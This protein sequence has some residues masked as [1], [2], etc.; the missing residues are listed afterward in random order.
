L[1]NNRVR[2][3]GY[4]NNPQ[5][6]QPA[7]M[8][9]AQYVQGPL[10]LPQ[11]MALFRAHLRQ[12]VWITAA[13]LA[14]T[15]LIVKLYPK[16]YTAEATVLVNFESN[17]STRQAPQELYGS[18]LATQV[19]LLLDRESVMSAIDKLNLTSDPEF[20][21]GFRDNGTA[22][23]R[24]WAERQLRAKLN[25]QQSKGT[26][27]ILVSV[28]S[29]DRKKAALIANAIVE[30]YQARQ[31]NHNE[32]PSNRATEYAGQLT[33]L[34]NKVALAEQHMAE[35][36]QRTGIADV[37]RTNG[38][39]DLESQTLQQLEQEYLGAQNSRRTAEAKNGGDQSSS[40]AAL[41]SQV[42]Q[43]L[44]NQLAGLQAQLAD[45]SSTLGPRHPKVIELQSQIDATRHQL[46]REIATVSQ[47]GTGQVT[48]AAQQEV[49]LKKAVDDQRVKLV[50]IRAL[51]D[52][53]QKLQLELESAQTVYKR[54]LDSYDQ[55]LFATTALVGRA[56][57]PLES[58]PNKL[59]LAATG[60]ILALII[61]L[62]GPMSYELVFNRRLHCRD[63]IERNL[64]LPV[65]A[66]FDRSPIQTGAT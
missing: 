7:P 41:A 56:T 59:M 6:Q 22:T 63:D 46:Q 49:K 8:V 57:P 45:A 52:E 16:T 60:G 39:L 17:E 34:K 47:N 5:P 66:E 40:D 35:F 28:T 58:Q 9:P 1:R 38:Q 30:T 33:D 62:L 3:L 15:L 27:L 53:G 36:R 31:S 24:D 51:Q 19:D 44:K 10:S 13:L 29:H 14:A 25:V 37:E 11:F 65:L 55:V 61:G 12:T 4:S 48:S 18:Y 23:L 26:Q 64:G 32:D 43:T 54:A 21:S 20:N 42:V 50:N 2:L